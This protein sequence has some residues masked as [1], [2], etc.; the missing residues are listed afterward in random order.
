MNREP[1]RNPFGIIMPNHVN[2]DLQKM[3]KRKIVEQQQEK[4]FLVKLLSITA[5]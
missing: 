3:Q 2:I 1:K 4:S 5:S